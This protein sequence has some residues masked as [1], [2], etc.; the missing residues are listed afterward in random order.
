MD[1][2]AS[3]A[4]TVSVCGMI[5]CMMEMLVS[6]TRLEKTVRFVLGAFMLCSVIIPVTHMI[7]DFHI[8]YEN[9]DYE[10]QAEDYHQQ[11]VK[12]L[13]N[14]IKNLI[15]DKLQEKNIVWEDIVIEMNIDENNSIKMITARLVFD[16]TH[17]EKAAEAA[18]IIESGLG[19]ETVTSIW[20]DL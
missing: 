7:S 2:A 9:S 10:Y 13:K 18:E 12:L 14:E 3:W 19:I 8:E 17:A 16:K 20:G 1:S 6:E 5:A 15:K 11:Q 4:I